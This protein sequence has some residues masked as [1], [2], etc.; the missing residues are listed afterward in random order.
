MSEMHAAPGPEDDAAHEHW[1]ARRA[2]KAKRVQALVS[3][4]HTSSV[5]AKAL[6]DKSG[7]GGD[8]ETFHLSID[9]LILL[10]RYMT[11][12]LTH[13]LRME[14]RSRDDMKRID[15]VYRGLDLP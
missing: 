6:L 9:E 2:A 14:I 3:K 8:A 1:L 4:I 10:D 13:L 12:I 11:S 7:M 15:E 5:K